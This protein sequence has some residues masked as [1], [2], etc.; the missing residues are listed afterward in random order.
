MPFDAPF[1]LGPFSVDAKGRLTPLNPATGPSF[2]FRWHG[3]V[4]RA[5]F[6]GSGE[7]RLTLQVELARVQ[8]TAS[9]SDGSLRPRS[10]GVLRWLE[11]T[12]PPT[13]RVVLLADHRIWL[14]TETP[15]DMPTTAT[16]LLTQLTSFALELA[17][18]LELMDEVGLTASALRH[19]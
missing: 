13:W 2:H 14:E 16:G 17:P 19:R 11:R 3:R 1:K 12:V 10:F 8:S 5:R 18:Y 6:A 9:G 15:I 4:V 7:G